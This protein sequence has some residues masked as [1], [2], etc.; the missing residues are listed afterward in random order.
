VDLIEGIDWVKANHMSPAVANIS[1]IASGVSS[2]LDNA[3][4]SLVNS[5]VTVVIAAGN[6]NSDAC[7][8]SPG[9]AP[10]A[11]TVGATYT[12]DQKASYSNWGSCLDVWAPGTAITSVS[13]ANDLDSRVM[14][15][16]S[17]AS[18]HVAGVAALYLAAN[19]G[20]S[21]ATVAQNIVDTS[22]S[23]IVTGLDAA[24]PNR[25]VYSLLGAAPAPSPTLA[26]AR[27]TIKKRANSRT[28]S[29]SNAAFSFNAV[30]FAASNFTLQPNNQIDDTNV[31]DFG[32]A[33]TITVTEAQ[34][35]GWVL[36]SISCVETSGGTP[37]VV[38][39]TV[40][41][42]N[43]KANIV[44]EPGEQVE[45]TFTS[46][47]IA[48]TAGNAEI[49][50]RVVTLNGAGVK[51]VRFTLFD[52]ETGQTF[53]ATSNSFGYYRFSEIPVGRLY[54]LTAASSKRLPITDNVRTFSLSEDISTVNFVVMK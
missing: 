6:A 30:N 22:T 14:S 42:A 51:G 36:T 7:N 40:D 53:S 33:N 11:I 49:S 5:G 9:R 27:V 46:D 24:S 26:P 8:Y 52:A 43:R 15:G 31:T 10:K 25:M 32:S 18:P 4:Q 20:A 21:P 23:G 19:P 16:T 1:I 44:A 37:N 12:E 50:G 17:M 54:T 47:E 45:C 2:T 35:Y 39:S 48:P 38:N 41:L 28:E 29:T 13:Y 3:I 34:T